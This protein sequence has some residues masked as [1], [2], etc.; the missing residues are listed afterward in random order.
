MYYAA[1]SDCLIVLPLTVRKKSRFEQ[2]LRKMT[3][4]T[5]NSDL[6]KVKLKSRKGIIMCFF[7]YAV[8]LAFN[9]ISNELLELNVAGGLSP[10][11]QW[12]GSVIVTTVIDIISCGVWLLQILFFCSTCLILEELFDDLHKRMP[13]L[14]SNTI[15]LVTL[16]TEY[17]NLCN[18]VELADKIF[19]PLLFGM[20]SVYIPIL[21]FTLYHVT[22]LPKERVVMTLSNYVFWLLA[23]SVILAIILYFGSKLNEKVRRQKDV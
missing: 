4:L 5:S 14:H 17:H 13:S 9:A 15:A 1:V 2:F 3:A 22:F 20:V 7:F 21:C 18:V 8:A 12:F 16:K 19:A 23:G 6:K 11:D 10:W